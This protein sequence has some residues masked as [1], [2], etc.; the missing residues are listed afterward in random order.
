MQDSND[1]DFPVGGSQGP[2]IM[3][4]ECFTWES[5]AA[6]EGEPR[7]VDEPAMSEVNREEVGKDRTPKPHPKQKHEAPPKSKKE[8]KLKKK[9]KKASNR[10]K[11]GR[12]DGAM[13]LKIAIAAL[14]VL[15]FGVQGY[16]RVITAN[17]LLGSTVLP[18]ETGPGPNKPTDDSADSSQDENDAP[19]SG[20]TSFSYIDADKLS[21]MPLNELAQWYLSSFGGEPK[22]EAAFQEFS[23]WME[24]RSIDNPTFKEELMNAVAE[25]KANPVPQDKEGKPTPEIPNTD[26]DKQPQTP[27][28]DT[29]V[30]EG[31]S[32]NIEVLDFQ[33]IHETQNN[34][35]NT[36]TP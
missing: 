15:A 30:Q 8:Q 4:N 20:P 33:E 36:P 5:S 35:P 3:E 34:T 7:P 25:L 18:S 6:N 1:Y 26:I 29:D 32:T 31:Q 19:S 14:F 9:A 27:E 11:P 24:D 2:N 28:V 10:N 17:Q 12:R 22:N 21:A 23:I 16:N 13:V